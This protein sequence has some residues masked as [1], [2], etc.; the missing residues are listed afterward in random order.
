MRL[1]RTMG[2]RLSNLHAYVSRPEKGESAMR[3]AIGLAVLVWAS[4]ASADVLY[5]PEGN[6]LHRYDIESLKTPPLRQDVF[7]EAAHDDPEHGRDINGMICTVPDG[8]N[9]FISGED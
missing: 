7:I 5:S 8:T 2:G 6:R 9:R 4:G 3:V 1:Q